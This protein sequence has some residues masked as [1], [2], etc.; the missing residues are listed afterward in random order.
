MI[1]D[2]TQMQ[3][4]DTGIVREMQGGRGLIRKLQSMGVR[5]GKKLTKVS[6][7]FWHGPQTVM[8]DYMQIAV[9]FRIA[10]RIIVE[11]DRCQ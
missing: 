2:V 3:P 10:K 8:I 4:G 6:S 11:L 7:H 1:V 5:P 9:G